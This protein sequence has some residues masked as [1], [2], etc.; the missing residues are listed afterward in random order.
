MGGVKDLQVLR[1]TPL[2]VLP[3][4]CRH[5]DAILIVEFHEKQSN[6]CEIEYQYYFLWVRPASI[7]D[8]PNDESVVTD[9][10]KVGML[11]V[12]AQLGWQV[13]RTTRY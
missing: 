8:N 3:L 12:A 1:L 2:S 7:E 13:G 6:H 4:L 11:S 10:P 5:P 9:I